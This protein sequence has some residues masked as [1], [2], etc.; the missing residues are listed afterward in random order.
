MSDSKRHAKFAARLSKLS[1]EIVGLEAELAELDGLEVDDAILASAR[2]QLDALRTLA[3]DLESRA[4]EADT[5]ASSL[6]ELVSE[7]E[8][9][10]DALDN[11]LS[12]FEEG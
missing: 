7:A 4:D 1:S 8:T 2:A 10:A 3:S 11:L 12:S 6:R 9:A 5:Y